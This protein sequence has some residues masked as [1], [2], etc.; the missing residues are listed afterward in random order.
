MIGRA[1]KY[2]LKLE[3]LAEILPLI[4]SSQAKMANIPDVVVSFSM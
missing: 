2:R 4:E 3:I 1:T